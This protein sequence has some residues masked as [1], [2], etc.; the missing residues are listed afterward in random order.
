MRAIYAFS[1][2]P[3]T[4]GHIDIAQRAARTYSEVV[5]AIGENPQK[6]GDY[7]FTSDERLALSQQCF[8]GLDNV[9]CVRFTGLLAEYAYRND[10]DFIVRGVRNNSDLEGEMVQ[11]AVNDILHDGVDTVFYPTRPQLSHISSSVVKAIVAEGGDVS[12][13]CPLHVKEA[14]ER[15]IRGTF[16]IGIAGGIAAGKTRVAQQLVEQL[17]KQ[18]T[19]TYISLDEV[20]HYVLSDSDDAIYRKTRDRIVDEFGQ[21]LMLEGGAIDRR[22]LG[23][24]VF[25]NPAALTQLNQIMREPMMARLYEKTQTSPRGIVVL[26]GAILVEAQWTKLVNN[27]IILV[28][29]SEAVRLERLMNRSQIETDEARPK[30]ERQVSSDE[31]RTMIETHI[32][33]DRWGRLWHLNTDDGNPDINAVCNDILAI[34]EG[35]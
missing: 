1:G 30:I 11:F 23:Q 25:A 34:F 9:T 7:L 29:A 10:F 20:G 8:D 5:V 2:D 32:A 3:I 21:Q 19:A 18:V 15:R 14:L 6:V 4:Y 22:A 33:N 12:N 28:D 35:R 26:E 16:T 17:Q 31:R 24:I 13:Y 27:N